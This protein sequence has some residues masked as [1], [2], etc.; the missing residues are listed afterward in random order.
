MSTQ[1]NNMTENVTGW[2][3]DR[4]K[5]LQGVLS[6]MGCYDCFGEK[7]TPTTVEVSYDEDLSKL[8][9]VDLKAIAKEKGLKGYSGLRKAELIDLLNQ[10]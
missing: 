3:A 1:K 8:K 9:L 10:N 2:F 5:H 4:F 6:S 7:E